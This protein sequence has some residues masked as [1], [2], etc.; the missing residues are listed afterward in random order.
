MLVSGI[1]QSDSVI[2]MYYFSYSFFII[3]YCK[4]LNIVPCAIELDLVYFIERSL[5][6]TK[7]TRR[8]SLIEVSLTFLI[9]GNSFLG[10]ANNLT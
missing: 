8:T 5:S 6:C 10:F 2:H 4:T 9:E 1:Q 3:G 7:K